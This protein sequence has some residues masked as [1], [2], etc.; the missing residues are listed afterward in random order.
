VKTIEL[1]GRRQMGWWSFSPSASPSM[2]FETVAAGAVENAF[3]LGDPLHFFR[4]PCNFYHNMIKIK[5]KVGI[6]CVRFAAVSRFLRCGKSAAGGGRGSWDAV[7][8]FS[9]FGF[10]LL[11]WADDTISSLTGS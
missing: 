10:F 2:V 6:Y 5:Y 4:G 3:V 7:G 11:F 8:F 1:S 9:L